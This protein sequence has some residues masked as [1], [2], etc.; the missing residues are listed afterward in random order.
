MR[1]RTFFFGDV[2][3]GR[4]RRADHH[5]VDAAD[6]RARAQGQFSRTITRSAD[7][8]SRSPA[9]Q[10]PADR[11]SIRW[12][13]GSSATCRRRRPAAATNNF[14][15]NSPSDQDAQKWDFRLDH[16]H[17]PGN[18]NVYFRASYAAHRQRRDVAAAAGRRRQLRLGRRRRASPISRS[19]CSST[20]GSGRRRSSAR[21]ASAGTSIAWDND[22]ARPAA[23]R[24]RHSRRRLD[25]ARVLADR[26]HRLPLARRLERAEL[27]RLAEPRRSRPTSP[28]AAARTRSRRGVQAYRLAI[29]FLSSQ[30]SSGIFNFN[31]QYTGDAVRRLPARLR[32]VGQP[33]EV[34]DAELP[35]AAT[36]TSSCRTTGACRARLTLN[37]GLR[38]ELNP[39]PV[40]VNDA[41]ANF[42]LDTDPANPRHRAGRR[43]RRRSGVAARCRASTT[44]SSRRAPASPTACPA[45]RRSCA[46]ASASSTST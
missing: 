26:H 33:V 19:G 34:G 42:D 8:A 7:A 29:D 17:Q 20:T 21:C 9:T 22:G 14:V 1:N 24:P 44:S 13:R 3:R 5:G 36:R 38:Y 31:G 12:R 18:Q 4:I 41:I 15:Y 43:G 6:R 40:D 32:V 11:A 16:D 27:R 28:G 10:I 2:E 39:P 25:A 45:T 23:A 35:H 46:A 30:R 37:L